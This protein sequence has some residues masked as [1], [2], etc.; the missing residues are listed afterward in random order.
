VVTSLRQELPNLKTFSTLSPLPGFRRWLTSYIEA[1]A[2]G[3]EQHPILGAINEAAGLL[4]TAAELDAVLNTPDWWQNQQV[5]EVLQETLLSLCA[6]YL[7]EHRE[8]DQAPLDPVARFHLGN[9]A[10]IERI[11]WLG[12]ISAKGMRE[13]CGF[14]VNYLYHLKEM[15]QNIEAYATSREIA[16]AKRVRSLLRDDEDEGGQLTRLRRLISLTRGNGSGNPP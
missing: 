10:R 3:E 13:S 12:D 6:R 8:K 7:H 14:M 4:G 11:N 15:E 9:G 2:T 1:A 5:T 16:A